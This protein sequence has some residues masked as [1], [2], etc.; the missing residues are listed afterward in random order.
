MI[1]TLLQQADAS[2]LERFCLKILIVG[3]EYSFLSF[4]LANADF[5]IV[6]LLSHTPT[7]LE[8]LL[9]QSE[10][11]LDDVSKL[12]ERDRK[13]LRCL[14]SWVSNS[15]SSHMFLGL[16]LQICSVIRLKPC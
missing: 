14:L 8:F 2:S 11:R 15:F 3:L 4:S 9:L 7:V 5:P 13:V 6:Q 1:A 12:H 16:T 10:Q